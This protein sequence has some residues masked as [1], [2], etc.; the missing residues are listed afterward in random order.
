MA[1]SEREEES[2]MSVDTL[3]AIYIGQVGAML[4]SAPKALGAVHL[5]VCAPG[6]LGYIYIYTCI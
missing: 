1:L 5:E 3:E 2:D 4:R 6:R